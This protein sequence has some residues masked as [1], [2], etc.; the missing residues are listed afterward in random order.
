MDDNVYENG[1]DWYW[2]TVVLRSLLPGVHSTPYPLQL[3][4]NI[5]QCAKFV[6]FVPTKY[7]YST[8]QW[9]LH[10]NMNGNFKLRCSFVLYHWGVTEYIFI[11]PKFELSFGGESWC[12]HIYICVGWPAGPCPCHRELPHETRVLQTRRSRGSVRRRNWTNFRRGGRGCEQR[13]RWSRWFYG[14]SSS[15]GVTA[16]T[17]LHI[18]SCELLPAIALLEWRL[19]ECDFQS[20]GSW[21]GRVVVLEWSNGVGLSWVYLS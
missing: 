5:D 18:I 2:C 7:E 11:V 3:E 16:S 1:Y 15:V 8:G 12:D 20:G 6:L 14:T 10:L 9:C 4:S 17:S 13:R 19:P 21:S